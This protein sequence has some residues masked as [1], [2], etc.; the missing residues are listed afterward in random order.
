MSADGPRVSVV[1]A[2]YGR[3]DALD[4]TLEAL[5][6]VRHEPGSL[7][8]VVV[9]DG[10]P[11]ERA[12]EVA[13]RHAAAADV[14]IHL[15]RQENKGVSEARNRGAREARGELLVFLSDDLV[16]PPDF[17]EEH[18]RAH[19]LVE[20]AWVV[21]GFRQ[22][23]DTLE[24][25]VGRWVDGLEAGFQD[26][27]L[28]PEIAPGIRECLITAR[29]LSLPRTDFERAGGFDPV[30]RTTCEDV[31]LWHRS[32]ETG[33]R[34]VYN[35]RIDALHNEQA[36]TLARYARFQRKGAR[37]TVRLLARYPDI[38]GNAPVARVNGPVDWAED[39]PVGVLRKGVKRALSLPGVL[40]AV[41]AVGELAGRLPLPDAARGRI[42]RAVISL[43]VYRGWQ[44]G[45]A[46][47]ARR[48][49]APPT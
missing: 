32:E 8:I 12:A 26:A 47:L 2:T 48:P 4:T 28:G 19:R 37:D 40:R 43:H 18:L 27:R 20:D 22:L 11:G 30:F 31:D 14:P 42:Y 21:G 33:V 23:P 16:V 1:I 36:T 46:A 39:G 3:P 29:N 34:V 45:M 10:S 25:P 41:T 35:E 13:R 44:E 49:E 6:A 15:V 17:L 9:D 7:E 24:S 38:H 5:R